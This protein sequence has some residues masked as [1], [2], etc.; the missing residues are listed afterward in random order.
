[1]LAP[2]NFIPNPS[3]PRPRRTSVS[4]ISMRVTSLEEEALAVIV[5]PFAAAV[6]TPKESITDCR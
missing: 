2:L 1:M 4:E 5:D 6:S 3:A